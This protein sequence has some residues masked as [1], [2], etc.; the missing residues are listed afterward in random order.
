[1]TVHPSQ[2]SSL[3]HCC[4]ILLFDLRNTQKLY[5]VGFGDTYIRELHSLSKS[6]LMKLSSPVHDTPVQ[7]RNQTRSHANN[8][9]CNTFWGRGGQEPEAEP[10]TPNQTQER[11]IRLPKAP[12]WPARASSFIPLQTA[13]SLPV[14]QPCLFP[15]NSRSPLGGLSQKS[16]FPTR[17]EGKQHH[18]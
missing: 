10:F 4:Q 9:S 18:G 8:C 3:L 1:M 7:D 17:S 6:I 11:R 5:S 16:P 13:A 12:R 14:C 2:C 15:V